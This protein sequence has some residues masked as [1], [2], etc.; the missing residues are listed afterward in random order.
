MPAYHIVYTPC[1][2]T[3]H[4]HTQT[5]AA[6]P[7][8]LKSMVKTADMLKPRLEKAQLLGY[9]LVTAAAETAAGL[10][11]RGYAATLQVTTAIFNSHYIK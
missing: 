5:H 6:G 11:S 10:L 4:T 7:M 1:T 8:L 9:Y 3:Q 2:N